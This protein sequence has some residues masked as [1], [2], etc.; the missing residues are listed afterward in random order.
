MTYL[1]VN[2]CSATLRKCPRTIFNLA[3]RGDIDPQGSRG[4]PA[5]KLTRVARWFIYNPKIPVRVNFGERYV[6]SLENV[7]IFYGHLVHFVFI[8]YILF[9]FWYRVPRKI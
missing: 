3:P 5:E 4:P 7:D 9:R 1:V 2:L 6:C 8:W